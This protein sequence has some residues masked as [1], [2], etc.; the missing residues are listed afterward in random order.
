MTQHG[1]DIF[2]GG[3]DDRQAFGP[4]PFVKQLVDC[5]EVARH[6]EKILRQVILPVGNFEALG[7]LRQRAGDLRQC[8]AGLLLDHVAN[9][10]GHR[11]K[12]RHEGHR[13][14]AALFGL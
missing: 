7:N 6:V 9:R 8:L 12:N 11:M 10:G 13:R 3:R 14:N 1:A 5:G 4:S 2:F